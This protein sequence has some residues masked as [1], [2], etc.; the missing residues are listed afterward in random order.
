MDTSAVV[1]VIIRYETDQG[2][3]QE[4]SAERTIRLENYSRHHWAQQEAPRVL[5]TV[6]SEYR[7]NFTLAWAEAND[8]TDFDKEVWVNARGYSSDSNYL[9]WVNLTYQR[10]NVFEGSAGNWELTNT[11]IVA[12]GRPGSGTRRG[13]TTTTYKQRDGWTT[14][15]YTVRPV[16]RFWPRTGYAF[17]SRLY[18]PRTGALTDDRIGFPVSAGCV[19]MY[20]EDIWYLYNNIPDGTTVVIH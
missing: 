5:R 14:S 18:H 16:V 1:R 15:T 17:H 11:F 8:Y 10:V 4:L 3:R 20:S 12:T 19:R 7:G 6:T 2:E 9:L 13:V